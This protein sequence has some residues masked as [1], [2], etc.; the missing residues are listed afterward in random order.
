MSK[1]RHT[2]VLASF[3]SA[4]RYHGLAASHYARAVQTT[5]GALETPAADGTETMSAAIHL[6]EAGR[7]SILSG[8]AVRSSIL[9]EAARFDR[10]IPLVSREVPEAQLPTAFPTLLVVERKTALDRGS[11]SWGRE[12]A[13]ATSSPPG[14]GGAASVCLLV[15]E[16]VDGASDD[17][18]LWLGSAESGIRRFRT[19]WKAT[20]SSVCFFSKWELSDLY[21]LILD[22]QIDAHFAGRER[23]YT[24]LSAL[25][26]AVACLDNHSPTVVG[27]PQIPR[28]QVPRARL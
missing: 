3:E 19:P 21:H 2:H 16:A 28:A 22:A 12:Y 7:P 14:V 20:A 18:L 1:S 5:R 9:S 11:V 23:R 15:H 27:A 4:A 13:R 10:P 17:M 6:G 8:E 26:S 24:A 25:H